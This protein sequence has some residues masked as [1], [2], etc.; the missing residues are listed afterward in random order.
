MFSKLDNLDAISMHGYI[1]VAFA[2]MRVNSNPGYICVNASI[3]IGIH[4]SMRL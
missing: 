4:T 3:Y 1:Y 2:H